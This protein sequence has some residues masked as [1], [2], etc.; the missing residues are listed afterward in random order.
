MARKPGSRSRGRPWKPPALADLSPAKLNRLSYLVVEEQVA[1][2]IG[3]LVSRW[4]R[5]GGN[6]QPVFSEADGEQEVVVD[7][8]ALQRRLARR[9]I[10]DSFEL[11]PGGRAARRELQ[12]REIAVGDVFA[13]RLAGDGDPQQVVDEIGVARWIEE[14]VDITPEGRESAKAAAYAALTPPLSGAV[15]RELRRKRKEES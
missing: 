12:R 6:G 7:G 3:L 11:G 9:R 2:L 1:P 5:S 13:A 8:A 10:P 15:V 14:I 4:P